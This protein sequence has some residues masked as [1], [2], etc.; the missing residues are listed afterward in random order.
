MACKSRDVPIEATTAVAYVFR[1]RHAGHFIFPDRIEALPLSSGPGQS[2]MVLYGYKPI[3]SCC[4]A[5][6]DPYTWQA[7]R[8]RDPQYA[9]RRRTSK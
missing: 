5:Y 4:S 8:M 2:D 7:R 6:V 1:R 9:R 3:P